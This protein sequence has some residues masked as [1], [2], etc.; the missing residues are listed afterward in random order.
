MH[1]SHYTTIWH[2]IIL[3]IEEG[4][5]DG[6]LIR[7]RRERTIKSIIMLRTE[8]LKEKIPVED[9]TISEH[10]IQEAICIRNRVIHQATEVVKDVQKFINF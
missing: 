10:K 1:I 2:I 6:M 3:F 9:W 7:V 4:S 5:D 8:Q